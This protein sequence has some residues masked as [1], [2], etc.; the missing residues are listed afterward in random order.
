MNKHKVGVST[1]EAK[2]ESWGAE[3]CPLRCPLRGSQ[4]R[5]ACRLGDA[6]ARLEP[7]EAR[8]AAGSSRSGS[9]P[10]RQTGPPVVLLGESWPTRHQLIQTSH[11][12]KF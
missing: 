12:Y 4:A 6:E 2:H 5:L 3:A 9:Q 8:R 1:F 7:L 11:N 10:G